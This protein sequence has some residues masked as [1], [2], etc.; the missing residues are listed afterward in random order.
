[1]DLIYP[2]GSGSKWNNNEIRFSIRSAFKNLSGFR[3]IYVIG[4]DPGCL[5]HLATIEG[6]EI[7]FLP[8]PDKYGHRNADGNIIEKVRYTCTIPELSEH[9]I[10][11]NDDNYFLKH[12][13]VSQVTPF[14]KGNMN[15]IDPIAFV[16]TWGA[17]LGR[18]RLHLTLQG[19]QPLHF[20]HHAP[21]PMQKSLVQATYDRFPDYKTDI[22]LTVKSLYGSQHYPDAPCMI[23]EKVMFR[24]HFPLKFIHERT[25]DTLYLANND[26]GLTSAFKYFL[27]LNFP[28]ASPFETTEIDDRVINIA[29][30]SEAG[31]PYELGSQ[32]FIKHFPNQKNLHRIIKH[33]DTYLVRKKIDYHLSKTLLSL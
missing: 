5:Q 30:W 21:F 28:T 11:M 25:K 24:A 4:D 8:F 12:M 2:L 9:F 10:M 13:H 6:H 14:H 22:G 15:N 18:T 26:E 17:R 16:S 3:N 31:K 1:M 32:L 29:Q 33:N 20:D 23:D 19:L 27:H 7:H